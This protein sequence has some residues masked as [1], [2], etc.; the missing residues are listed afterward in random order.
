MSVITD[1]YGN[2]L[3]VPNYPRLLLTGNG[4]NYIM[5]ALA[6]WYVLPILLQLEKLFSPNTG[7]LDDWPC[8]E[9]FTEYADRVLQ[10]IV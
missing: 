4:R 1:L 10:Q 2:V 8:P 5:V 7:L 6:D 3:P 9:V